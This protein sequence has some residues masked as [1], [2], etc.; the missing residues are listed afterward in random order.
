MYDSTTTTTGSA[1]EI[2]ELA[3]E[4]SAIAAEYEGSGDHG[5]RRQIQ[6][7]SKRIWDFTKEPVLEYA[8]TILEVGVI[9]ML[10]D[11]KVFDSIPDEGS[12]SVADLASKANVECSLLERFS[13]L[14]VAQGFLAS[15]A[16]GEVAHTRF[17]KTYKTGHNSPFLIGHFFD[18]MLLPVSNWPT[19][20]EQNGFQEP[21]FGNRTPLG[22]AYGHPDDYIYKVLN[23]IPKKSASFNRAMGAMVDQMPVLGMYDFGWIGEYAAKNKDGKNAQRPLI[24][25]VGGNEGRVLK[26]ILVANPQIPP[27]QCVVQDRSETI[28][29]ASQTTDEILRQVQKEVVDI[30]EEQPT[31]EALV[32]YIRRVFNDWPDD[33]CVKLLS[34]IRSVAAPDSRVLIAEQL[35]RT[36]P[37]AFTC[38]IDLL[39]MNF[40]GKARSKAKFELVAKRAGWKISQTF[41][42]PRTS[43]GVVELVLDHAS[44]GND[45]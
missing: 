26:E 12:I 3:S 21:R 14:L 23:T 19:Y 8:Y 25:D 30:F 2:R 4:L 42:D 44:Q 11:Y 16:P 24:V 37:P 18:F 27:A 6:D 36:P 40:G 43:A 32:Y 22:L 28:K 9:K 15:P 34:H 10:I 7:L 17:S 45:V 1:A 38:L 35:A 33:D 13:D 29:T 39:M 41:T 31:K 5:R 20:F